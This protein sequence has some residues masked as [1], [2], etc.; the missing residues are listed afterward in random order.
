MPLKQ[1][2][3]WQSIKSDAAEGLIPEKLLEH[4]Y[5]SLPILHKLIHNMVPPKVL[6]QYY[7]DCEADAISAALEAVVYQYNHDEK[8]V[9]FP[10]S[11]WTKLLI[12]R[13]RDVLLEKSTKYLFLP[14]SIP[15]PLRLSLR[16]YSDILDTLQPYMLDYKYVSE[17]PLYQRAIKERCLSE[18]NCLTECE[19]ECVLKNVSETELHRLHVKV[20][21]SLY[22]IGQYA[23]RYR[24]EY[25]DWI[26]T[27]E[28]LKD[29]RMHDIQDN[30]DVWMTTSDL[31]EDYTLEQIKTRMSEVH[32]D[33]FELMCYVFSDE[34]ITQAN[35]ELKLNYPRGWLSRDIKQRFITLNEKD[36][37]NLIEQGDNI[38][39]ELRTS[40]G[41]CPFQRA[42]S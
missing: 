26:E 13:Y 4:V 40:N 39:N 27:L 29:Y 34:N 16:R 30:E 5:N 10:R 1:Q 38:I 25:T 2:K 9:A 11:F 33:L 36:L 7:D 3:L 21:N 37:K 14:V 15:K 41:L 19:H 18:K 8:C 32:P 28:T 12:T 31:E 20:T 24:R 23:E 17:S 22:I 6:G 35:R 42:V